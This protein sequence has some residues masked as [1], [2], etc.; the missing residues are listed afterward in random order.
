MTPH[1]HPTEL[2]RRTFL[3]HATV[4]VA[5]FAALSA[6]AKGEQSASASASDPLPR[7]VPSGTSLTVASPERQDQL[8]LELAGLTDDLPFRVSEWVNISAGPDVINAY[9]ANSLEV[10]RNAGLPPIQAHHQGLDA[11]IVA[12]SY[13]RKPLYQFATSPG[14][15]VEDVDDFRDRKLAFSQGQAQGA[16]LLRALDEA[17]IDQSDVELVPLTS[18]QFLTAL[19]AGQ[20]D[21]APL[22][23]QQVPEYLNQYGD[24][25]AHT[26]ETDVVDLLD[27][28]WAPTEVIGDDAKVAAIAAYIPI[29]AQAQVWSYEHPQEWIDEY[30]VGTQNL[31]AEDGAQIVELT[32]KP[33][34]PPSWDEAVAWEQETIEL[35][36]DAGFI[37]PFEADELFDR[38]FETLAAD[39]V[40]QR[41]KDVTHPY[42]D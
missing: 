7:S 6:C 31:S 29:W 25:G 42:E 32:S 17:G 1:A 4:G 8:R 15:D 36:A 9:R 24:E 14:S 35:L 33:E 16:V 38:R 39:V 40:E 41:Y 10:G 26:I 18:N 20:V 5:A 22:S 3:T 37:D 19:Q 11:K 30:Y 12:V 27:I 13:H 28:L 34:F 23:Q 21:V 2:T